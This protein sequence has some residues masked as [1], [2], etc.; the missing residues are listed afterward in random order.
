MVSCISACTELSGDKCMHH[1]T[2]LSK[3]N[4]HT[5]THTHTYT[6][7]Q[8]QFVPFVFCLPLKPLFF[9]SVHPFWIISE[10]SP[11]YFWRSQ[12]LARLALFI[13]HESSSPP[14]YL[15]LYFSPGFQHREPNSY[16]KNFLVCM[17]TKF[18]PRG[19]I[20]FLTLSMIFDF[21]FSRAIE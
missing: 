10:F 13:G 15:I 17:G 20:H 12:S 8:K 9:T 4:T 1:Y 2:K 19:F 14:M 6:H 16:G 21:S 3:R 18:V 11:Q 5:Q 7:K